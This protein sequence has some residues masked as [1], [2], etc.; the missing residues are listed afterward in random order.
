MELEKVTRNLQASDVATIKE[1]HESGKSFAEISAILFENGITN[2][3]TGTRL[4]PGF[5]AMW[6]RAN[7]YEI[8]KKALFERR[9][10]SLSLAREKRREQKQKDRMRI[11][12]EAMR[13]LEQRSYPSSQ[14]NEYV[15]TQTTK[16]FRLLD[17][18]TEIASSN[19]SDAMKERLLQMLTGIKA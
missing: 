6:A 4:Q 7:G 1:L 5:L 2:T 18:I 9:Q 17:D 12:A 19:L 15:S 11:Q 10:A 14:S 8:D 13:L 16:Q 3:T